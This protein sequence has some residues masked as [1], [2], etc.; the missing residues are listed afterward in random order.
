MKTLLLAV[1]VV[2]MVAS[3]AQAYIVGSWASEDAGGGLTRWVLT[4]TP[5]DGEIMNG[6]DIGIYDV[7]T[8]TPRNNYFKD[9]TNIIFEAGKNSDTSFLLNENHVDAEENTVTDL[10]VTYKTETANKLGGAFVVAS[11]G[12]FEDGWSSALELAE[13]VVTT[14]TVTDPLTQLK[15]VESD[16]TG[17]YGWVLADNHLVPFGYPEPSTLVMLATGSIGWLAYTWHRRRSGAVVK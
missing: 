1:C 4:A 17:S 15:V 2:L 10:L 9:N 14:G 6:F 16:G 13:I 5:I 3:A 12:A 8:T 11:G 7:K